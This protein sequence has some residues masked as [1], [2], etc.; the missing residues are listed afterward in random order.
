MADQ[1]QNSQAGVVI[2]PPPRLTGDPNEDVVALSLW[3]TTFY[4]AAFV[5]GGIPTQSDI[6]NSVDPAKATA[7]TAQTTANAAKAEADAS[8]AELATMAA[9]TFT[10][11]GTNLSGDV[12][13]T[14]TQADTDYSVVATPESSAGGP[15][16][17]AFT[18]VGVVK[19]TNK[20]TP[21]LQA[22]PG[23]GKSVTYAWH[24]RR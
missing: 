7:E 2:Q 24:L 11:S 16:A 19:S 6:D 10:I 9:G 15:A 8:K 21:T 23:S 12:T 13:L 20:F 3:T 17:G 5:Q 14:T 4:Q 22:A 1:N 18:I